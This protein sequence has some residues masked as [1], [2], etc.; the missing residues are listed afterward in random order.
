M[1]I[2]DR[3]SVSYAALIPGA[4][5][6]S[7][8]A[9]KLARTFAGMFYGFFF[10]HKTSPGLSP[11]DAKIG[12]RRRDFVAAPLLVRDPAPQAVQVIRN[13]WAIVCGNFRTVCWL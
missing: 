9:S 8:Q 10:R 1:V 2:S 4:R 13:Q 12:S 11:T 5:T 6:E 3:C 7:P